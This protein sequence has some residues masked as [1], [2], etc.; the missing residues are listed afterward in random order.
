M[1]PP[2]LRAKQGYSLSTVARVA[3]C[4]QVGA[5]SGAEQE[6][7]SATISLPLDATVGS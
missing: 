1:K 7:A 5:C 6:A 4:L 2:R 3:E